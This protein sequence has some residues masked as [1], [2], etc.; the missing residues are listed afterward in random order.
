M[1]LDRRGDGPGLQERFCVGAASAFPFA[2]A[3]AP[4]CSC[5]SRS[6]R[7]RRGVGDVLARFVPSALREVVFATEQA[8]AEK[9]AA[10]L[11]PP[12]ARKAA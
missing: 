8:K 5:S 12:P 3:G 4:A 10:R 2:S 6:I 9:A 1:N 11:D 7:C